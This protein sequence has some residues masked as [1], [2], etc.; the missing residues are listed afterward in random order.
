MCGSVSPEGGEVLPVPRGVADADVE[1]A[2]P[3]SSSF[4]VRED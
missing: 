1:D 4:Q 2:H 3:A